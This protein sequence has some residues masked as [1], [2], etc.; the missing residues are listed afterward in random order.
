MPNAIKNYEPE[1]TMGRFD[2]KFEGQYLEIKVKIFIDSALEPEQLALFRQRFEPLVKQYWEDKYG[3]KCGN[4]NYPLTYKPRF[5]IKYVNAFMDAHFALT[6]RE[7]ISAEVVRRADFYKVPEGHVGF[8]PKGAAFGMHS[9]QPSSAKEKQTLSASIVGSLKNSFPFYADSFGGDLSAHSEAE[10]K[11]LVKEIKSLDP[12][13]SLSVTA[14]GANKAT[15]RTQIMHKIQAWGL[16]NVLKRHSKKIS[17][18][19]NPRTGNANY[20]KV[21]IKKG[22]GIVDAESN[23]LFYY[24]AAAVHEFGHMIGLVDE[25]KCLSK[26][27]ADKMAE[28]DFIDASESA[29]YQGYSA[30]G[31]TEAEDRSKLAQAK[32]AE[33]C[34]D[35]GCAPAQYGTQTISLMSS[36]SKLYP[37]HY[38]TL[39]KVLGDMSAG[40]ALPNEWSIVKL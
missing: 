18:S 34:H 17:S 5:R 26:E 35:A 39:W 21:Q 14:Y 24:P 23:G 20:V 25:Y 8:R 6:L 19:T 4:A 37:R 1:T 3:F 38:V 29:A 2:A 16:P 31:A 13:A 30:K 11:L 12:A 10:L 28:L 32:L 7:T 22:L 36:G 33:Y 9:V 40:T 27:A 15:L